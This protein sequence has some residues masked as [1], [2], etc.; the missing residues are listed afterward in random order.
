MPAEIKRDFDR[1]QT[2]Q[3]ITAA[4]FW[5]AYPAFLG[6]LIAGIVGDFP[7]ELSAST[8]WTICG[9][10]AALTL[11]TTL[12]ANRQRNKNV[13]NLRRIELD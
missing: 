7:G 5:I 6:T 1:F 3:T 4:T 13:V 12:S 11:G 9:I 2:V 8:N 10:S